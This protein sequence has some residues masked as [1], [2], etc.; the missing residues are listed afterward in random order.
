MDM[1]DHQH[2]SLPDLRHILAGRTQFSPFQQP[3]QH[4]P[5]QHYQDML[6]LGGSS[7]QVSGGVLV[8]DV[9]FSAD[10]INSTSTTNNTT[11]N[12][13]I[14][15]TTT[16][17][18]TPLTTTTTSLCGME[19]EGCIGVDGSNGRWPRQETLTLLEIRSS[20]DSRFKEANQKGPLWDEV[21]R[22]MAEEH[23]YQRS[24]KKCREK[25]EN[26]YKYYKKTRE[27]KAGRQ[28]GKHYRFFRQL[29]ALYGETSNPVSVSDS[30][31]VGNNLRATYSNQDGLQGQKFSESLSISNSSCFDTSSSEDGHDDLNVVAFMENDSTDKKK[32]MMMKGGR[33]S[34]KGKIRD[35]VD[36]Q[37]KK[38][39]ET[40]EAWLEK[41]LKTLEQKEQERMLREEEGR[42]REAA[43]IDQEHNFWAKERAWFEARD[44]ALMETLSKITGKELKASSPEEL[45]GTELHQNIENNGSET[46]ESTVNS[47]EKWPESEISSLIHIRTSL[48]SR[49]QQSEYTKETLW[50]E[51]SV[52]MACFGYDRNA[53][54]C[55]EKWEDINKYIRKSN[56]CT[57]KRKDN[58]RT[59]PHFQHLGSTYNQGGAF[60]GHGI[61]QQV[62]QVAGIHSSNNGP[63]NSNAGTAMSNNCFQFLMAEGEN[64]WESY[65]VRISRGD[66][67]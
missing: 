32:K 8:H 28:D 3:Q 59:C 39:M 15:T 14:T 26:L 61:N 36:S 9:G 58:S 19:M 64:L 50:E 40:Q 54:R 42:K 51:V 4:F 37:M 30:H 63:S 66:N 65:G 23:G 41:M 38:L 62:P 49:F 18:T 56:D 1:D 29:E 35:F 24:G 44:A 45:I 16:T 43:R 67:Q 31:F 2:Y 12:T 47:T 7:S 21:S 20:L 10:S 60:Y 52:K 11:T 27:G 6:M 48:E 53:K 22:I 5:N 25:F 46:F 34:W 57:M 17:T 13:A 55:E 33:R